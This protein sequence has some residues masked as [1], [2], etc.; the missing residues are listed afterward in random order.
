MVG[1]AGTVLAGQV[2]DPPAGGPPLG[3]DVAQL[4]EHDVSPHGRTVAAEV[5]GTKRPLRARG[6]A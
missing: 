3:R 4:R 2:G 5:A 1:G 6:V